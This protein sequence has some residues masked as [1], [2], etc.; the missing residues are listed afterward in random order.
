MYSL[1][2]ISYMVKTTM[3]TNLSI[4]TSVHQFTHSRPACLNKSFQVIC[5]MD[6]ILYYYMYSFNIFFFPQLLLKSH[7]L[8]VQHICKCILVKYDSFH[9]ECFKCNFDMIFKYLMEPEVYCLEKLS[10]SKSLGWYIISPST[11]CSDFCR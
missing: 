1:W 3:N 4:S 5:Y 10:L 9:F 8:V 11:E 7:S 6:Q 2:L